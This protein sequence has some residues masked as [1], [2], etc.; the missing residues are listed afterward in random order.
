MSI[1]D[2][3]AAPGEFFQS[4][5]GFACEDMTMTAKCCFKASLGGLFIGLVFLGWE[6]AGCRC[7]VLTSRG[8]ADDS[9]AGSA[10][11]AAAGA[12]DLRPIFEHWGLTTRSQ[13][14]RNTCSVLTVAGAMEYALA[15]KRQQS[16][17][18]LSVEFLNWAGNQPL[19]TREDGGFFADLWRGFEIYG[20]CP[21]E[22]MPYQDKF[23]PGANPAIKRSI[24][25]GSPW[26]TDCGCNG[27][28]RGTPT[29]D[30]AANKSS[31]SRRCSAGSGRSAAVSS[32]PRTANSC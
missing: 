3:F 16:G 2:A 26:K 30:S 21:E 27:S 17:T 10:A 9:A 32:G 1:L 24:T 15:Q 8:F 22:D 6:A 25:P 5:F 13:G 12:A 19:R 29:T 11:G 4:I 28:N 18:R 14:G 23:D 7:C 20:V 31:P